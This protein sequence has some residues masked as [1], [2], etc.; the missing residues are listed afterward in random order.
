M[1]AAT[2]V[3]TAPPVLRR[4][5]RLARRAG[6]VRDLM[7][8]STRSLRQVRREPETLMPP[9]IIPVFFF[10]IFVGSL[11]NLAGHGGIPHF[12]AFQ[13]PV[14]IVFAVTG[15][16]RAT[17]LVND[18]T[19]GYFD[20]LLVAPTNR[21]ALLLGLMISDLL[22]VVMLSIPVLILG[23]IFGVHFVTG[24][25]GVLVFVALA[26]LWGLAFAGIP[27]AIALR[28]GN[29][30]VVAQSS[31]LFFP[32]VFITTTLMPQDR[33][34]GWMAG[35][36]RANPVTYLLAALRSLITDGWRP[37]VLLEGLAVVGAVGVVTFSLALLALRSRVSRTS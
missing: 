4:P 29:P 31:M 25:L 32:F 11:E 36:S 22:V 5:E 2:N 14:S 15:T 26:V 12:R 20:R 19:N 28:T 7:S 27:Y 10:A 9:L 6:F 16:T 37:G 35:A 23:F 24:P 21:L 17:S 3:P 30:T 34:S 8:V 33:L 1:A 18:I 13:L